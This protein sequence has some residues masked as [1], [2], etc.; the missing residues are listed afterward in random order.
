MS[1]RM[2][3]ASSERAP[4][5]GEVSDRAGADFED[6]WPASSLTSVPGRPPSEPRLAQAQRVA[7]DR[8]GA[9]A[10]GRAGDHRT[11]DDP[12]DRVEHARRD[13]DADDVVDEGEEEVLA[14]VAHGRGGERE[15]AVDRAQIA[16]H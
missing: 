13:R 8:D 16:L 12:E 15:G 14:D 3:A 6:A 7:D 1:A 9:Q 11:E 2:A 4:S 10:H 5:D